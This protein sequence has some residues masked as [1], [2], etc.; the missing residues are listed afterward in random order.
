MDSPHAITRC[1]TRLLELTHEM[2]NTARAILAGSRQVQVHSR[3]EM[4]LGLSRKSLTRDSEI[5][6]TALQG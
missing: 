4:Q 6:S 5:E 1:H 3:R 2:N